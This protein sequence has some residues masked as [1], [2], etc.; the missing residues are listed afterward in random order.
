M[1]AGQHGADDGSYKQDG[2]KKGM[3]MSKTAITALFTPGIVLLLVLAFFVS[4]HASAHSSSNMSVGN[5]HCDNTALTHNHVMGYLS[6]SAGDNGLHTTVS[7]AK[8]A[9][10]S[11][12]FSSFQVTQGA[13]QPGLNEVVASADVGFEAVHAYTNM[14]AVIDYYWNNLTGLGYTQQMI[15]FTPQSMEYH[16]ASADKQYR[17]VFTMVDDEIQVSFTPIATLVAS[18]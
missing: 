16:F 14:T 3:T 1:T 2:L 17:A 10:A 13:L 7:A 12:L 18:R 5:A 6:F 11:P 8:F 4:G 9:G 15:S